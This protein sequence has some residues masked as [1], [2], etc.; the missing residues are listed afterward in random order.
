MTDELL[1]DVLVPRVLLNN[2]V[3]PGGWGVGGV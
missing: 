2:S 1:R 3:S